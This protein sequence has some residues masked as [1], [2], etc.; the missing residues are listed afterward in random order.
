MEHKLYLKEMDCYNE[1]SKEQKNKIPKDACFDLELL[2]AIQ[3]RNELESFIKDRTQKL[4]ISTIMDERTLYHQFCR[5]INKRGKRAKSL[6]DRPR[7]KWLQQLKGWMLESGI[8]LTQS[9]IS[10][11]GNESTYCA[12]LILYVERVLDFLKPEDDMEEIEKDIWQL[13]KLEI[14][15]N[16]NPIK[17]FKT[18]NFTKIY[19]PDIRNEVKK[20]IYLNLRFEA[21]SCIARE[22]T[23]MRRLSQFLKEKCPEIESCLDINREVFEEYLIYLKTE[24]TSTKHYHSELTRLRAIFDSI[25][26]SY[27]WQHLESLILTR[28]IP[29]ASKAEFKAYSDAELKRLNAS[30]VKLDAQTARTMIIHQM[31]GLR[32]SDTLTLQTDCLYKNGEED[33]IRIRQM[34]T[35]TFEK[36][37][38][39][40]VAML[41]GLAIDDTKKKYGKTT[42][43]FVDEKNIQRPLQYSTLQLKI[44]SMIMK[45]DL[46]DDEG[47]IFGFGTHL[48]RH[49]Y[50]MKLTEMHLDDWTIARLLGHSSLKNV[51]YYRKMS[52]Q[53]MADETRRVRQK[54]SDIIEGNLDGWGEEY[55]KIRQDACLE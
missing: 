12:P 29:P 7:E 51:K 1:A 23:A 4:A 15:V 10:V 5:F 55:E 28:D 26:K 40:E 14:S 6:S 45:E 48:Y 44:V 13:D 17:N 16:L 18:L 34:K 32:I 35:H 24:E 30:I 20:G 46:R 52:N 43:I 38:S 49:Y 50:G 41:I 2:P 39:A 54:L 33:M 3:M 31:L 42:Y 27:G 37:I 8:K 25:G 9:S 19:Q 36:P 22:L 47:R 53:I 21:I 11:Y